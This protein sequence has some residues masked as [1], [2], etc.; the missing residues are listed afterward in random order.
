MNLIELFPSS[1]ELLKSAFAD[2]KEQL[3]SGETSPMKVAIM[4]KAGEDLF[5]DLRADEDVRRMILKEAEK[6]GKSFAEYG[7]K[8]EIKEAGVKYDFTGCND[9]VWNELNAKLDNL[10]EEIKA[11][12]LILKAHKEAWATSDGEMI[13]PPGKSSTTT[14]AVTLK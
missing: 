5:K 4:L 8:F 11:R 3:L 14:V 10:K 6:N 9:S 2:I 1:K 7:A 13:Y 12:E